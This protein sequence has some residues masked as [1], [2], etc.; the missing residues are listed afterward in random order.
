MVNKPYS[1]F[2]VQAAHFDFRPPPP[3]LAVDH[4]TGA[5]EPDPFNPVPDTPA[6]QEGTIW[7]DLDDQVEPSGQPNLAAVPVSHWF[8]GQNAVPSG[9]PYGTAQQAMQ[10]RMVEDHSQV[11]YVPDSIRLYQHASEGTAA[12][13]TSGRMPIARG[14]TLPADAQFLA[15]GRNSFDQINQPNEVYGSGG[16]SNVGGYRLGVKTNLW[17]LY[18]SPMGRFGQDALLH[19]YTGLTPQFPAE[20]HQMNEIAAPYTP[21]SSGA[22]GY[23]GP[24]NSWQAPSMF[25]IPSETS[26]TDFST[27][28]AD[29]DD[30]GDFGNKGRL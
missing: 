4:F 8:P 6:G 30:N 28:A 26:I 13:F 3:G 27:Q 7:H 17:G 18:E 22:N 14:T 12:E 10:E 21:N 15:N 23:W 16:E 11:N 19:A 2:S 20:K 9:V 29:Y 5:T 24:A 1:G 25:G